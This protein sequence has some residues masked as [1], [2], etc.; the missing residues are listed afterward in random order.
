MYACALDVLHDTGDQNV[1]AVADSIDLDLGTL[2]IFV[3]QNRVFDILRK[4]D[5]HILAHVVLVERDNHVLTAEHVGR[6]QQHRIA[7]GFGN[8]K[9][10]LGRHNGDAARTLDVI[11]F[12]QLVKALSVLRH[13]NGVIGGAE[14]IHAVVAHELGELDSGLTAERDHD[15]VGVLGL[16][17][18]HHVLVGERLKVESVGG[19]KVGRN[20]FGVVVDDHHVVACLLERPYAVNGGVVEL[21][22]LTDTDR[23]GAEYDDGLFAVVVLFDKLLRFVLLVEGR[24]EVRRLRFKLGSA[25]VYHFIYRIKRLLHRLTGQLLDRL[26]EEAVFLGAEIELVRQLSALQLIGEVDKILELFEEPLVDHGDLMDLRHAD[27]ALERFIEA[28]DT[29]VVADA[30]SVDDGSLGITLKLLVVEGVVRDLG[31]ADSLHDRLLK[32]RRDRHDLAGRLHLGA[33]AA[34]GVD[35][36][37]E[38]PLGELDDHIVDRRLKAGIGGAGDGVFDLVEGV[39][40]G[41]LGGYLCD[42]I[43]GRLGRERRGTRHTRI[44]LDDRIFKGFGV[45]RELAVAAAL[46]L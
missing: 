12:E 13:I 43:T 2:Q 8:V 22:T 42:G 17:N 39:T 15:A 20:G 37:V 41:D 38:R 14:N 45:E 7:D 31:A 10:F 4:N 44:D 3:D 21:D 33:E 29:A 5:R 18:A 1:L 23:T 30:Q 36:F 34:L 35:E 40:D 6:T 9:R 32:G 16:D 26:V 28:E 11:F 19:V 24:I 27:A 46:N 25:G